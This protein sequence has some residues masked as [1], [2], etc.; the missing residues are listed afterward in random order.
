[1]SIFHPRRQCRSIPVQVSP[2]AA[3]EGGLTTHTVTGD[4]QAAKDWRSAWYHS[5]TAVHPAMVN[6]LTSV[7]APWRR[8]ERARKPEPLDPLPGPSRGVRETQFA[9]SLW[10]AFRSLSN[11]VSRT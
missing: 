1:M 9:V 6:T 3:R 2:N 5:S 7:K 10:Y 8:K 4:L 11:R